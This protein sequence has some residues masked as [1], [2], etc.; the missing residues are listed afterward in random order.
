[1]SLLGDG[2]KKDAGEGT[3]RV[4]HA[5]AAVFLVAASLLAC[6]PPR[7]GSVAAH[8]SAPAVSSVFDTA[9]FWP[10][11][12]PNL[13]ATV[14]GVAL[15]TLTALALDRWVR[16]LQGRREREQSR[17]A[18]QVAMRALLASLDASRSMYASLRGRLMA[19]YAPRGLMALAPE[20]EVTKPTILEHLDD[21]DLKIRLTR[22][23]DSEKGLPL[24]VTMLYEH[25]RSFDATD[26][27][28]AES[29]DS[30][31]GSI[32][33]MAQSLEHDAS[34]LAADIRAR[35]FAAGERG[36]G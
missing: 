32:I 36:A 12:W 18:L 20:W 16:H 14:I 28:D 26:P 22:L 10:N 7:P 30:L 1:V 9:G 19:G 11:F 34:A 4:T 31:R 15:G 6:V 25:L 35:G 21:M 13:A 17:E 27:M 24:L 8:D 3:T 33:A 23:F 5:T 2:R 29:V